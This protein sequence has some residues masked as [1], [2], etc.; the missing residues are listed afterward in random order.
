MHTWRQLWD[1]CAFQSP[2][3]DDLEEYVLATFERM[4]ACFERARPTLDA[5]H[6]YELR[7]EDLL[8]DPIGELR[9]V[10]ERLQLPDFAAALPKLEAYLSEQKSYRTNRHELSDAVR[11]RISQRWDAYFR[12]YGY[13]TQ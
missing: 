13:A 7:Y 10:Y 5:E 4:Y 12:R 6:L 9:N 1:S 8:Q 11:E 3:F 2:Q